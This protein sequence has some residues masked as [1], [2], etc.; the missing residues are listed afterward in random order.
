MFCIHRV[1]IFFAKHQN[2]GKHGFFV[3]VFSLFGWV[4]YF[5]FVPPPDA[6]VTCARFDCES[7]IIKF[8]QYFFAC[9][10]HATWFFI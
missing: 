2:R 8:Q 10:I 7:L 3:P 5:Y 9:S 1:F 4:L 6:L